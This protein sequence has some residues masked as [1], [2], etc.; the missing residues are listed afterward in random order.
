MVPIRVGSQG[1]TMACA[2]LDERSRMISLAA[3]APLLN[4]VHA[5]FARHLHRANTKAPNYFARR[6][7]VVHRHLAT[8]FRWD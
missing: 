3:F 7:R 8:F 1:L 2:L 4:C 5:R 6:Q